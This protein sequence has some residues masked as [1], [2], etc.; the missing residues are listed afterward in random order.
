MGSGFCSGDVTKMG[1]NFW[2][3]LTGPGRQSNAPFFC[4]KIVLESRR[5]SASLELLIDLLARLEPKLRPKRNILHKNQ[6]NGRKSTS[7]P[8]TPA[9]ASDYSPDAYARELFKLSQD[10]WSLL[11]WTEKKLLRLV[12]GVLGGCRLGWG[13]FCFFW[14]FLLWRHRP[15]NG[16][17]LWLNIWFDPRLQYESLEP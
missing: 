5:S 16:P 6:K 13:M 8:L 7:L 3:T 17:K 4:L 9:L 14:V 15:D 11:V 12:F 10:S 2:P 1:V